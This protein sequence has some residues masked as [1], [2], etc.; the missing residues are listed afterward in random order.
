MKGDPLG[1]LGVL[2]ERKVFFLF[3]PFVRFV[4]ERLFTGLVTREPA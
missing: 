2:C 1:V 3:V 4:V